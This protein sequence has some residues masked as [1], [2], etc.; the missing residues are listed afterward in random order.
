[1]EQWVADNRTTKGGQSFL[2]G[3]LARFKGRKQRADFE[4]EMRNVYGVE[5]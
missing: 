4:A 2:G 1:M 3:I 5:L